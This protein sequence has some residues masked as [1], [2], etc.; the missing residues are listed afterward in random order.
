VAVTLGID[1]GTSSCKGV[2]YDPQGQV[3]DYQV[4][5]Y[6]THHPHHGWVEQDPHQWLQALH[7]V[8]QRLAANPAW[9]EVEALG[10]SGQMHTLTLIDRQGEPLSPAINW[11]DTRASDILAGLSDEL[12]QAISDITCNAPNTIMTLLPLLWIKETQPRLLKEAR[13]LLLPKDYLR[14]KLTDSIA[15]DPSDA[16]GTLLYDTAGQNWSEA[17][18]NTFDL[19]LNTLP[20]I[21]PSLQ[22]CGAVTQTGHEISGIPAGLP[23]IVGAGDLACEALSTGTT[24]SKTAIIRCGTAGALIAFSLSPQ[25]GRF[26]CYAAIEDP[27]WLLVAGTQSCGSSIDWMQNRLLEKIPY[28][29]VFQTARRVNPS[30]DGLLFIPHLAGERAPY[31]DPNLRAHL[32]G[33][34][35][36]HHR[37]HVIRAVLEG[38]ALSLRDAFTVLPNAGE[39]DSFKFIGGQGE[40]HFW[41]QLLADVF[42]R[43]LQ[44]HPKA[45]PATGAAMLAAQA[46]G[47]IPIPE[48]SSVDFVP[49]AESVLAYKE[50]FDR[51]Q[52]AIKA[53]ESIWG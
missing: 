45:G 41:G 40:Q 5:A 11:Q 3:L 53:L 25:I 16:S 15:T 21:L 29:E 4:V 20:G 12:R 10:I 1:L 18:V 28:P 39:I 17:L 48:S 46:L 24:S 36:D 35:S 32:V 26:H 38:V 49:D 27:G 50:A 37:D 51:Y 30:A 22:I 52:N 9:S 44:W 2:L 7:S 42:N 14:F 23:V 33:L 6:P 13:Y 43:P 19:P 8:C 34:T 47:H 31:F